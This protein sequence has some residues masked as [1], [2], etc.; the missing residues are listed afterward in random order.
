MRN[1]R[2]KKLPNLIN[3]LLTTIMEILLMKMRNC[4]S[5]ILQERG[6]VKGKA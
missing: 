5:K 4:Q 1:S 2:I 3:S 6:I